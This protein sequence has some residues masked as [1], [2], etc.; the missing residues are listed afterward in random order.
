MVAKIFSDEVFP[1]CRGQQERRSHRSFPESGC[2]R[3]TGPLEF[4]TSPFLLGKQFCTANS[5]G[6]RRDNFPQTEGEINAGAAFVPPPGT[7]PGKRGKISCMDE[8]LK[9]PRLKLPVH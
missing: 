6:N 5:D 4:P 1:R 9:V 2:L 7:D 8:E 3:N